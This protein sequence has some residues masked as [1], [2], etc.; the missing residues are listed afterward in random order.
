MTDF[1]RIHPDDIE[2]IARRVEQL[3]EASTAS[4]AAGFTADAAAVAHEY[5]VSAP[6]VRA[7]ALELGGRRLGLGERPR[8]RFNLAVVGER[9]EAINN[10]GRTP[11][12][13]KS[14]PVPVRAGSRRRPNVDLLPVKRCGRG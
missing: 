3:H 11:R 14:P 7:H 10:E 1:V 6:W 12:T 2:A 9:L 13:P 5:G 4:L 8:H